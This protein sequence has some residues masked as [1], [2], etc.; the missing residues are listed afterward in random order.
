MQ[1]G[2]C[3]SLNSTIDTGASGGD[4]GWSYRLIGFLVT[5]AG[6]FIV[7]ADI[8]RTVDVKRVARELGVRY[9]LEGSVRRAGQRLRITGQLID[10]SSFWVQMRKSLGDKRK[11][12]PDE[13]I[14]EVTRLYDDAI[15]V[16]LDEVQVAESSG[17]LV[18][19]ADWL[20]QLFDLDT[21]RLLGQFRRV[22]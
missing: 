5:L 14:A 1:Y 13:A 11:Y 2:H 16:K 6:I 19:P 12:I 10:A 20:A 7:S 9:V 21:T 15:S 4:T 8:A 18:L 17:V 3:R 22:H